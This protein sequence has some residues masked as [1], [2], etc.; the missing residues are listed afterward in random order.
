MRTLF[1]SGCVA[2]A[3]VAAVGA[4]AQSNDLDEFER[5]FRRISSYLSWDGNRGGKSGLGSANEFELEFAKFSNYGRRIQKKLVENGVKDVDIPKGVNQIHEAYVEIREKKDGDGGTNANKTFRVRASSAVNNLLNDIEKVKE[6]GIYTKAKGG[7]VEEVVEESQKPTKDLSKEELFKK[8]QEFRDK[9]IK[10]DTK[11]S[12]LEESTITS[13]L[14]TITESQK[15]VFNNL[16]DKYTRSG[17]EREEARG[18][19]LRELHGRMKND[20]NQYTRDDLVKILIKNKLI[21]KEKK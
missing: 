7:K 9:I 18:T 5:L 1:L 21:E 17:F 20:A 4:G 15:K 8:L 10:S 14:D 2:V 13:Y 19:A 11:V 3:L 12:G 16:V 6:Y